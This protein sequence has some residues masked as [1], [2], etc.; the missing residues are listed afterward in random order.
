[1]KHYKKSWLGQKSSYVKKKKGMGPK[2]KRISIH[3]KVDCL[4]SRSSNI[5]ENQSK[6]LDKRLND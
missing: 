6:L 2:C 3:V 1:M 4:K 5:I